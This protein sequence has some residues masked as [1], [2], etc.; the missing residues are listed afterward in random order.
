[1]MIENKFKMSKKQEL[2]DA[3]LHQIISFV[4]SAVRII[5]YFFALVD[6]FTAVIIL[7][8]SEAIGIAEELV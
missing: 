6:I 7:V 3:R 4:K 5:G 8:I 2:P 1:M